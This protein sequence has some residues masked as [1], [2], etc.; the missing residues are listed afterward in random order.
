[1]IPS[2][3]SQKI[4]PQEAEVVQQDLIQHWALGLSASEEEQNL[5]N[6]IKLQE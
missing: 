2:I 5:Q 3:S 1:M 6:K 4:E